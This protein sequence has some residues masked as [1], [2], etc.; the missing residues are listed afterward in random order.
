MNSTLKTTYQGRILLWATSGAM[1]LLTGCK[2]APPEQAIAPLQHQEQFKQG[3]LADLE[4]REI[5]I[6]SGDLK[7]ASVTDT[8]GTY[9]AA[10]TLLPQD[11]TKIDTLKRMADLTAKAT[12][13][14]DAIMLKQQTVSSPAPSPEVDKK[15]S[16]NIDTMLYKSF[17]Q[18]IASAKSKQEAA[19]YLDL[20]SSVAGN[21]DASKVHV[22]Y[23]QAISLYKEVLR[24]STNP[25]ERQET[26]YKLARVY[27]IAGQTK[28][29]ITTLNQLAAEYPGSPFYVE[30]EFRAGEGY[31]TRG[32][33]LSA[34]D[35]YKK[36]MVAPHP[37]NFYLQA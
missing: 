18:G 11:T 26:Y 25:K 16:Q 35:S 19:A 1:I 2:S 13:E 29:S 21:V 14:R 32:D 28:E 7:N 31:F 36:V 4:N 9:K 34:I 12:E 20:A 8:L 37:G 30:A 17:M 10:T 15:I 23:N 3:T 27:D 22:D 33:F 5:V 6:N 24:S